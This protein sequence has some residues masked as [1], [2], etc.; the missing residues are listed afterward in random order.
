MSVCDPDLESGAVRDPDVGR[1][2]RKVMKPSGI[3]DRKGNCKELG[4]DFTP[5]FVIASAIPIG[6][7]GAACILAV[8]DPMALG[9]ADAPFTVPPSTIAEV[10]RVGHEPIASALAVELA[11]ATG[12]VMEPLVETTCLAEVSA[13]INAWVLDDAAAYAALAGAL[14]VELADVTGSVM[15]PLVE[16]TS[17]ADVSAPISAWAPADAT[18]YAAL[19]DAAASVTDLTSTEAAVAVE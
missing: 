17:L 12:S 15:E 19:A 11:D 3:A 6:G 1:S 9:G 8:R 18:A 2:P 5:A 4:C 16:T 13:T 10:L 14:A 7:G